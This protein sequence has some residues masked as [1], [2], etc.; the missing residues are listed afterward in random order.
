VSV[1]GDEVEEKK[2][3]KKSVQVKRW[4]VGRLLSL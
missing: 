2:K 4:K 1:K 3:K